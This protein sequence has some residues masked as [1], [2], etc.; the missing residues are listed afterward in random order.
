LGSA[1]VNAE[2]GAI[3]LHVKVG[4]QDVSDKQAIAGST[5]QKGKK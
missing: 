4:T 2:E 5:F 1:Y 3:D